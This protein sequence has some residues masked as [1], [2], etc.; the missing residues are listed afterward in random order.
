ML[1]FDFSLYDP[2]SQLAALVDIRSVRGTSTD[3]AAKLRRDLLAHDEVPRGPFL[4][5]ATPERIF[6]WRDE[7][8]GDPLATPDYEADAEPLF[9]PYLPKLG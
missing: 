6:L 5:V 1:H 3:W 4:L 7:A 9:R 2:F 8:E